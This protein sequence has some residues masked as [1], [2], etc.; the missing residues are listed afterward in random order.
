V[1]TA[2]CAQSAADS[3]AIRAAAMDYLEG[4]YLGDST[5]HARSIRPEVYKYGYHRPP[6]STSYR[7]MQMTWAG[8]QS[9]TRGVREGRIKTPPDAPK[10]VQ[11]LDVQDQTAAVRVDAW[12]G[13]DYLLLGKERDGRWMIGHVAWQ[14]LLR[15]LPATPGVEVP[16]TVRFICRVVP[17]DASI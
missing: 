4:F 15:Q 14:S 9:F 5:R 13:S 11:L 7:G 12:W 6:D 2:L 8:F 3:T 16:A 10:L 1:P 17:A